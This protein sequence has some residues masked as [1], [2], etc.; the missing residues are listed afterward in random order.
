ML[1]RPSTVSVVTAGDRVSCRNRADTKGAGLMA[2]QTIAFP[3][4]HQ[5]AGTPLGLVRFEL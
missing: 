4:D 3:D 5:D 1:E 2:T